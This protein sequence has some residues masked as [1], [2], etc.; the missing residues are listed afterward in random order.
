MERSFLCAILFS[1]SLFGEAP[2]EA[3]SLSDA[4]HLAVQCNKRLLIAQENTLQAKE[5]KLQAI[6]RYLPSIGYHA[7][8]QAT[9]K[10]EAFFDVFNTLEPFAPSQ[11]GYSSIFQLDQPIFS[12][13]LL[14]GLKTRQFEAKSYQCNQANTQNELLLAV[15]QSYYAVVSLEISLQIQKENIDYLS[16]A[17]KQEQGK[18]DAGSSTPYEVNQSKVAVANALSAYYLALRDLKTARNALILTL[19]IDPLLEPKMQLAETQ[20]PLRSLP[21]IAG[22]LKLLEARFHY[23]DSYFPTTQE[24]LLRMDKIENARH[25]TL[26]TERDVRQYIDQA[27]SHRPDLQSQLFQKEAAQQYLNSKK[28]RYLPRVDSYVRFSYNDVYLGPD[29]FQSQPYRWVGGLVFSW[30]LFDSF[31]REHEVR[32]ARSI[33]QAAQLQVEKELQKIE[34]EVRNSLYQWEEAMLAY[35]S[36]SQ[37]VLLAEQ[38]RT[39]ALDK[40]T[41]GRIPPLEYRDSI[42]LLAMAKNQLNRSSLDLITAYYQLQYALGNPTF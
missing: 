15:R 32:E 12:T 28:G 1:F 37:A 17:L 39:Q 4:E 30:D 40:L 27:L 16:Y 24:V 5:R 11:T 7:E 23:P 9:Q 29:P 33:K 14:F 31:L 26:F 41:F 35:L 20:I 42:N 25:L 13:D 21:E 2:F 36:S 6:S 3:L 38:A 22:K 10:Q 19:G 8:F 34:V 18:L